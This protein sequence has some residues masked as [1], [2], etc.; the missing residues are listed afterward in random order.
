MLKILFV[1]NQ[2]PY[3]PDNGVRIVSYH[4]M[5]LMR[6]AGHEVALA[7]LTEEVGG[8]TERFEK[9]KAICK[10]GCAWWMR[11][12]ARSAISIQISAFINR[13]IF[14]IERYRS[15]SFKKKLATLVSEFKPDVVHF[16]IITMCQYR[17]AVPAEVGIVAS[18]NDSYSLT[19]ENLFST[20][21]YRGI[22]LL[23]R[24]WQLHQT[25]K[26][27]SSEYPLFDAV[28]VMSNTDAHYLRGLN[29]KINA[30][31]IPNGVNASLFNI[32]NRTFGRKDVIF[33]ARLVGENLSSL[34]EFLDKSWPHVIEGCS[35]AVIYVVGELTREAA[36]VKERYKA[37]KGVTFTGYVDSLEDVYAKCGIAIVPIN[38]NCGIINK[39]IEAMAS[40]LAVVGFRKAFSG[41]GEA[42][43]GIHYMAV[44][45][46][47]EMGRAVAGLINDVT[48]CQAMKVAAHEMAAE[49]YSWSNRVNKYEV[50]YS[51][52]ANHCPDSLIS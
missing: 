34:S 43:E 33:V 27:E 29:P 6:N 35:D 5:Q 19:L 7:V 17:N 22:H 30:C 52:A 37:L 26:Y 45:D 3:P 8:L 10:D 16:D 28:H 32:S 31:V 18:I 44:D 42:R 49:Y 9:I 46:Y 47:R 1:T 48:R 39:A 25:R 13:R 23:Y 12:P 14:P 50:M 41:L 4:A 21:Q 2:I 24:K 20:G 11:L 36:L 38:K 40:G 15:E 51:N